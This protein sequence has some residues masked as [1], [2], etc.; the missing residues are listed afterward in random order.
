MQEKGRRKPLFFGLD[1]MTSRDQA[2]SE[3]AARLGGTPERPRRAVRCYNLRF[4]FPLGAR[5]VRTESPSFRR[6]L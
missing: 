3:S 6:L 2:D 5:H 1:D 4:G